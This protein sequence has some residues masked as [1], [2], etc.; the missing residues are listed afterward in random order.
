[1]PLWI[2]CVIYIN[3]YTINRNFQKPDRESRTWFFLSLGKASDNNQCMAEVT[4][5]IKS[6]AVRTVIQK[7]VVGHKKKGVFS[8]FTYKCEVFFIYSYKMQYYLISGCNLSYWKFG[9]PDSQSKNCS[10]VVLLIWMTWSD[11]GFEQFL[12][13]LFD[14]DN[15]IILLNTEI[16]NYNV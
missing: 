7:S 11:S 13:L 15:I 2:M 8:I 5:C 16:P 9:A 6:P 10:S 4:H 1:M 3:V 14:M 12:S